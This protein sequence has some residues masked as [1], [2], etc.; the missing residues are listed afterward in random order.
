MSEQVRRIVEQAAGFPPE[1]QSA[2]LDGA[3]AGDSALRREV[4]AMLRASESASTDSSEMPTADVVLPAAHSDDVTDVASVREGP[5]ATIGR[6]KLLQQIGEGGFGV[7]FMAEQK[8]PVKRRVALKV[9]KLGM[10]THQ[11]IAR[12]EA[13]RQ[14][15]A[16]MDHP[17]IARVLDAGATETGRPYFVMELVKGVPITEYCDRNNL[18]V[19]ER[20]ALFIPV[21][22]A[23][24]HAHQKGIIHRDLKPSNVMITLHDGKPVPKVIDFGIAKA[25][26][27]E[28]T[29]KTVFTAYRQ[30]IG[31]PEYMSP[32]QA[33]MSGLDIDTRSDVYSLGVMLYELVMGTTPFDAT[34]LRSKGYAEIQ[35]MIIEQEPPRLSTKISSLGETFTQVA[36]HRSIEPKRLRAL[37][38]GELDW[39]ALKAMEKDRTRRYD[40]TRDL[41]EDIQRYLNNEPV[42]AAPPSRVYRLRKMVRRNKAAMATATLIAL[43]LIVA[44]I[45]TSWGLVRALEAEQIAVAAADGEA[46]QRVIAEENEQRAREAAERAE[47]EAERA[48]AAERRAEQ[49]AAEFEMMASFQTSMLQ[50]INVAQMGERM[51]EAVLHE[52]RGSM[53]RME[54]PEQEIAQRMEHV[55]DLLRWANF[56]NPA[57]QGIESNILHRAVAQ[58]DEK[59]ADQPLIQARLLQA[60]AETRAVLGFSDEAIVL[61]ERVHEL[62]RDT[63]GEA[64]P[65]TIVTMALIASANINRG[66]WTRSIEQYAEA[67][68]M[69]TESLGEAHPLTMVLGYM[70]AGGNVDPIFQQDDPEQFTWWANV[71][72]GMTPAEAMIVGRYVPQL[73]EVLDQYGLDIGM[74]PDDVPS[75][76]VNSVLDGFD[77]VF[78]VLETHLGDTN[79][80]LIGFST[81]LGRNARAM[82]RPERAEPYLRNALEAQRRMLGDAHPVTMMTLLEFSRVLYELDRLEESYLLARQGLGAVRMVHGDEHPLTIQV[83]D[84]LI[85]NLL[86]A[87]SIEEAGRYVEQANAIQRGTMTDDPTGLASA[88]AVRGTILL[89]QD[90]LPAVKLAMPILEECLM[91]RETHLP[92]SWL[93]A[94]ARSLLGHA[95]LQLAR[96]DQ[97]LDDSARRELLDNAGPLLHQGFSVLAEADIDE[98]TPIIKLRRREAAERLVLLYETWNAL[99]PGTDH[100]QQIDLWRERVEVLKTSGQSG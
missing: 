1:Q 67:K 61:L 73:F 36:K 95:Q 59:F 39:I 26:S 55:E 25:T 94:N 58:I 75:D 92:D 57:V 71:T 44:V 41:A 2:F 77:D 8:E 23:I 22:H 51:R 42:L 87:D 54:L 46:A 32:E 90:S 97:T 100:E 91:L 12:F 20:L 76:V 78:N 27:T 48:L 10:D 28:L 98:T 56:T 38:Q 72:P 16:M 7:V 43:A 96:L 4:E 64:D 45:G 80:L 17:N 52:V 88:F 82:G 89:E 5:G 79:Q 65:E 70:A 85:Q 83:M 84:T 49:R 14:A 81:M 9:I 13:E 29:E 37:L 19:R 40:T 53:M 50:S 66:Q 24:Q 31:T 15:L 33:E 34:T 30:F 86:G 74:D 69:A 62:R 11:V 63:L 6:Y 47:R 68:A 93:T 60:V 18:P 99:E 21:C 35:R 3:C